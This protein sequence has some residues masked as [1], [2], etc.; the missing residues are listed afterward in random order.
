[1]TEGLHSVCDR[2]LDVVA[3]LPAHLPDRFAQRRE[4][5]LFLQLL[6]LLV[7]R[8]WNADTLAHRPAVSGVTCLYFQA[9]VSLSFT[10]LRYE[11]NGIQNAKI[12]GFE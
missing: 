9:D 6:G 3:A 4:V 10:A 5:V 1:M 2:L 12:N 11:T 8:V 7:D